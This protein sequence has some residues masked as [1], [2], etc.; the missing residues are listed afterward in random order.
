MHVGNF[1]TS[2][3]SFALYCTKGNSHHLPKEISN[4]GLFTA[5]RKTETVY[6]YTEPQGLKNT[7]YLPRANSM[8][9][10]HHLTNRHLKKLISR[11]QHSIVL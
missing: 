10:V 8:R 7:E 11:A 3:F 5:L 6:H 1:K 9:P 4:T 2:M